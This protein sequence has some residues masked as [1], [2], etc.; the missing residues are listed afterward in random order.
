MRNLVQYPITHSEAC[1]VLQEA[2]QAYYKKYADYM[3]NIHG[4]ALLYAEQFIRENKDAFEEFTKKLPEV[5]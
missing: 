1:S 4:L 2:Q 5:K 3:G